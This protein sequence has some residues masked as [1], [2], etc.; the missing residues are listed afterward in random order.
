MHCFFCRNGNARY[1]AVNRVEMADLRELYHQGIGHSN[2]LALA[3]QVHMAYM[4]NLYK[5]SQ[6]SGGTLRVWR[7]YEVLQHILEHDQ[8]PR[9]KI[10]LMLIDANQSLACVKR[11]E[12]VRDPASGEMI[13]TRHADA[14]RKWQEHVLRLYSA[15]PE[16]MNFYE[17]SAPV[18]LGKANARIKGLVARAEK[19][20]YGHTPQ[21]AEKRID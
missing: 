8:D 3:K 12:N 15:T 17:A 1:D 10:W 11:I 5:D 19:R 21:A 2:P 20:H 9:V 4:R 18:D 6:F 16:T 13:P 14:K 7:T